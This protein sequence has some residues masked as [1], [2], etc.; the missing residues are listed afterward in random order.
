LPSHALTTALSCIQLILE[1]F[2]INLP[3]WLTI[4]RFGPSPV[5]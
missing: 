4:K 2:W 1:A 3:V 5:A